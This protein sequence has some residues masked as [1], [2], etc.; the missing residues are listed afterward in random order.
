MKKSILFNVNVDW[1]FIDQFIP[2]AVKAQ[3]EGYDINVIA[4]EEEGLGNQIRSYGFNFFPLSGKRGSTNLLFEIKL[5]YQIFKIYKRVRPD[6]VHQLTV[7]P[8]LYGTLIAKLIGLKKIINTITGLGTS[9]TF[10]SNFIRRFFISFSYWFVLKGSNIQLVVLNQNDNNFF[11]SVSR[12][13]ENQIHIINGTGV[14]LDEFKYTKESNS[15]YIKILFV[16]RIIKDKG[17]IDLVEAC[18]ILFESGYKFQLL[19][20]GK[21]DTENESAINKDLIKEWLKLSYILFL[22]YIEDIKPV[23]CE[24]NIFCLPSYREG[25]S[26]SL[27]EAA[28]IGRPIITTNVPGCKEVVKNGINGFL[29]EPR[30]AEELAEKLSILIKNKKL[31]TRFGKASR[32]TAIDLFDIHQINQEYIR[33][34]KI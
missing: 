17:L 33:L 34:Y 3:A 16:G 5:F 4:I 23:L 24:C 6:V 22:G 9:F 15:S 21:W 31:R 7:K 20:A 10:T 29:V 8:V 19:I 1:F 26:L 27:T 32:K 28:A 13:K 2:L 25:L 12:L 11:N 30:N 14:D 18:K